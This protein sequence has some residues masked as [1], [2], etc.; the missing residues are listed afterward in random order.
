MWFLGFSTVSADTTEFRTLKKPVWHYRHIKS[1]GNNVKTQ[2]SRISHE[3][4]AHEAEVFMR[5]IPSSIC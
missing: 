3:P 1:K 5:H 2:N 4:K